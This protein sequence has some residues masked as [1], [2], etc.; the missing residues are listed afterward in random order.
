MT[1]KKTSAK[2]KGSRTLMIVPTLGIRL[3]LLRLTLESFSKE[4][5]GDYTPDVIV[6][7]PLKN[8]EAV[9]LAKE[10]GAEV[11]DD[12]RTLSG[13]INVGIK[14]AKPQHEFITWMGD[15]DLLRPHSLE[16]SVTKLDASP[17]AVLAYGYCDYIE[18]NGKLIY[19]NRAGKLAEQI[20]RWGPNLIPLPGMLYSRAALEK[21]GDFDV[22]LKYAMDLDM[23][24]RLR[25]LGRFVNTKK[26]LAAFRWHSSSTTVANRTASM[27]EAEEIK[28][29]YLHP[30]VRLFAPLWEAPV[31]RATLIA[32]KQV[33]KKAKQTL[34]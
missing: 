20:M 15:D 27:K 10:Y 25:K 6:V 24:L 2:N 28:R 26:T 21:A 33:S 18:D 29:R 1:Q 3:D 23:L 5:Q 7:V 8:K 13:A 11:V 19:T 32:S 9:A 22:N 30:T 12:P 16:A 17:G 34:L 31:R 4:T 14:H